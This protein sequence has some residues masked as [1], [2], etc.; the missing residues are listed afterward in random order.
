MRYL[1]YLPLLFIT[2]ASLS[3]FPVKAEEV[4]KP[5]EL[6]AK[7]LVDEGNRKK[8]LN[9]HEG[10]IADYKAALK[11]KPDY[12]RAFFNLGVVACNVGDPQGEVF[13]FTK[14]FELDPRDHEALSVRGLAQLKLGEV[15][16]AKQDFD[17]ALKLDQTQKYAYWGLGKAAIQEG[18][19]VAALNNLNKAIQIDPKFSPVYRERATVYT[20]IARIFA[21]KFYSKEAIA[22]YTQV[23]E[24][25]PEDVEG[26]AERAWF[27]LEFGPLQLAISDYQQAADLLAKQDR[28][29]EFNEIIATIK[30]LKEN[31]KA[32]EKTTYAGK[33]AE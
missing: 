4:L 3:I 31:S 12:A 7:H 22:D 33:S 2:C 11:I 13:Y 19:Y 16:K 5:S 6:P 14:V 27:Y 1:K 20:G 26:Y 10:A 8:E 25:Y 28:T 9:D 24:L 17:K 30:V 18:N 29:E 32:I 23:I 21:G 15:A